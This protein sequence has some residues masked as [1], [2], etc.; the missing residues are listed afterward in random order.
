[1]VPRGKPRRGFFRRIKV[2]TIFVPFVTVP[3][4]QGGFSV[5][6]V[7]VHGCLVY[8]CACAVYVC[9]YMYVSV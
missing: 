6:C 5:L 7:G 4:S 3:S 2:L 1:M 8:V 9:V